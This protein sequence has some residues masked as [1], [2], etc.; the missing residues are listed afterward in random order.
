MEHSEKT[1]VD[2]VL[3]A[4]REMVEDNRCN[5]GLRQVDIP[6]YVYGLLRLAGYGAA[7]SESQPDPAAVMTGRVL[8]KLERTKK[9]ARG[10]TWPESR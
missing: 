2:Q 6:T 7:A 10:D 8:E 9:P 3:T 1:V 4:A 5:K